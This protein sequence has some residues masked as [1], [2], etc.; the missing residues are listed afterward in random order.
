M[1]SPK[2]IT[3]E[4]LQRV[5]VIWVGTCSSKGNNLGSRMTTTLWEVVI[6]PHDHQSREYMGRSTMAKW[7]RGIGKNWMTPT[8][9][10][11]RELGL[12]K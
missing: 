4:A 1:K 3:E 11:D 12:H 6:Q 2:A 5:A 7:K 8:S 10:D 9:E